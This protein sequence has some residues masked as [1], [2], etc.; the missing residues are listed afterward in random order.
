MTAG[1]LALVLLGAAFHA[2]W[3]VVAKRSA[4]GGVVFVWQFGLVSIVA[5]APWA[6]WS[7]WSHPLA[8]T[9]A[10]WFAV[11]GSAVIHVLYSLVLQ[12]AYQSAPF[13]VV[14]PVARGSGPLFSVAVALALWSERPSGIGW[15]GVAAVLVGVVVSARG[16]ERPGIA[17]GQR[18][19][20][21]WGL[22]TGLLIAGYT[23]LDAWAVKTLGMSPIVFFSLGLLL[24]TAL[25]TPLALRRRAELVPQWRARRD[26]VVAVGVLSPLAYTLVLLAMRIAPLSYVAP[27]REVSMLLGMLLGARALDEAVKPVQVAAAAVM[28]AGVVALALA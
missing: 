25:L 17:G 7:W 13:S 26:A 12:R 10:M 15:A 8:L 28:V 1:A 18:R 24:R 21:L 3:N 4:G 20:V 11:T 14:Y 22:L 16:S 5:A 23:L 19:G 2:L 6:A 27:V 9:A